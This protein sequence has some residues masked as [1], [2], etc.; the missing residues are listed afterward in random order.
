MFA[1]VVKFEV[2]DAYGSWKGSVEQNKC[3][4]RKISNHVKMSFRIYEKSR[5]PS[6]KVYFKF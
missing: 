5:L 2:E 3:A 1:E 4:D 6:Q